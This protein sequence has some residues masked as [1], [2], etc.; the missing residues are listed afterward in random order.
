MTPLELIESLGLVYLKANS[1]PK[2]L[3]HWFNDPETRSTL[4]IYEHELTREALLAKVS[5]SRTSFY[6]AK[7]G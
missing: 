7:Q 5:Q 6:L 2:G 1:F 4:A 3:L